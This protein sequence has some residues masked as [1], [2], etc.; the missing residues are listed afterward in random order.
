MGL[1]N[2]YLKCFYWLVC[3]SFVSVSAFVCRKVDVTLNRHGCVHSTAPAI[4]PFVM[5]PIDYSAANEYIG[6]HYQHIF[7]DRMYFDNGVTGP[8]VEENHD[9]HPK[10]PVYNAR[11]GV[12]RPNNSSVQ[13]LGPPTLEHDGF[14]LLQ[15]PSLVSD[16]KDLP[17]IK[18]VYRHELE[19]LL[20]EDLFAGE[21]LMDIVI[22]NPMFRGENEVV[23]NVQRDMTQPN[24]PTSPTA[25]MV[26]ID[27][28]IGAY[29][30][31]GFLAMIR[32]SRL[33][34]NDEDKFPKLI[35]LVNKGHRFAVINFWRNAGAEPI[36]RQPL[37]VFSP[38]YE[39]ASFPYFPKSKPDPALSR[40]YTYPNMTPDELLVFKQYD[41]NG[42][43]PSDIWH[44][45]LKSISDPSA[46]ARES[47]DIRAFVVFASMVDPQKDR[48]GIDRVR[49][50]LDYEE[51]GEFCDAQAEKRK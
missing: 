27:Q 35:E 15:A 37:A 34:E 33:M 4:E 39:E 31:A 49:P 29:E 36:R 21:E 25:G 45:A 40:W 3:Y 9:L 51:S 47:F 41:R 30:A 43:Y 24:P 38:R 18:S 12:I 6:E 17:Q 16:W 10:E 1:F 50:I 7:G 2:K 8:F 28:D 22:W 14:T 46:P 20:R 48:F 42:S 11:N 23:S 44:C 32:N 5:H 26:H 13:D 19:K